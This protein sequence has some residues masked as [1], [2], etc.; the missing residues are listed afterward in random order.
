LSVVGG[1]CFGWCEHADRGVQ[2]V[3]VPPVDVLEQG[4]FKLFD[5]APRS[6]TVDQFGFELADGGL[7]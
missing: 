5:G 4:V 3:L 7:G 1:L 6:T 2:P